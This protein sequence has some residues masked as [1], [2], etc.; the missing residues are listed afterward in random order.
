ME[1]EFVSLV[2]TVLLCAFDA[3][4][5]KARY[6]LIFRQEDWQRASPSSFP[7]LLALSAS[8]HPSHTPIPPPFS[9][10]L[11]T[12]SSHTFSSARAGQPTAFSFTPGAPNPGS[13]R[14]QL[15]KET[16]PKLRQLMINRMAKPEVGVAE[17]EERG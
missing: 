10:L 3:F 15:Y 2:G 6:L 16:L 12:L 14:K 11:L 13:M 1:H 17:A 4:D 7:L 9:H 8:A 5:S